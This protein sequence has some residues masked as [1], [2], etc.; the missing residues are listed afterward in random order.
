MTKPN[1]PE[2]P[3]VPVTLPP[4]AETALT[5]MVST[6]GCDFVALARA[7]GL[8]PARDFRG[9]DLRGV[10]FGASD[11]NGFDFSGADLSGCDLS[12][13]KL[14][15]VIMPGARWGAGQR[16]MALRGHTGR[17][18]SVAFSPDG[19]RIVSGSFDRALRIWDALAG[20][21]IGKPLLGHKG[22]VLS[23][24]V[25]PNGKHIVSGSTDRT[26]R[27]WSLATGATLSEPL[28]RHEEW[29]TSV[30]FS[31]N[32]HR[33]ASGEGTFFEAQ[34]TTSIKNHKSNICI[35]DAATE[36]PLGESLRGHE[37]SVTT[38]VFS[39][40]GRRIVSG[41][42]DSSLRLWDA[43]TGAQLGEPLRGHE[44]S[45][46]GVAFSPDGNRIVSG[47]NDGTVRL[48]DAAT[49]A[50]LG[51][52]LRG[53]EG[54]VT[55]VAFS[56][57]GSHIVSGGNDGTLRLWDAATGAPLSE[58]LRGH[59]QRH[60]LER[61]V[62]SVA[63][64][65][66][67]SRI[68]SGGDDGK[69]II[70]FLDPP[71]HQVFVTTRPEDEPYKRKLLDKL[72]A[73]PEMIKR[74][75]VEAVLDPMTH[76]RPDDGARDALENSVAA[77]FIVGEKDLAFMQHGELELA[78]RLQRKT[79]RPRIIP[80]FTSSAIPTEP[81][82]ALKG[83]HFVHMPLDKPAAFN[84]LVEAICQAVDS[85]ING[86]IAALPDETVA[87]DATETQ[88]PRSAEKPTDDEIAAQRRLK[89]EIR[90]LEKARRTGNNSVIT[91]LL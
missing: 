37:K 45:V 48:W 67:G 7:A 33:M 36:A 23:V 1:S 40:D 57:D 78:R 70:W 17:V 63:F 20:V 32:G 10:D 54:R 41:S 12:Q 53:H 52:P 64:S 44:K 31:P 14:D 60:H 25:S 47:G 11:L 69:V 61:G 50:P 86:P 42:E 89:I 72:F 59:D 9:A 30:N 27:L 58:P 38:V 5:A 88:K 65:P 62:N 13:T 87:V 16:F 24:A 55:S 29:V 80:I 51:D 81:P 39:P 18:N 82:D 26:L 91:K 68:V 43:T 8:D 56:P 75:V 83:Y 49:G 21:P 79:G 76:P 2:E 90:E 34:R 28:L 73:H 85:P 71:V 15:G 19:S 46:T 22:Q 35:W 84:A 3:A 77:L 6:P 66:D 4:Q 74:N